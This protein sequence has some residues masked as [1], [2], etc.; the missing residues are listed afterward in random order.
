MDSERILKQ[1]YDK[2]N[3]EKGYPSRDSPFLCLVEPAG[4]EPAS[5]SNPLADLHA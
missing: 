3:K 4:I 2:I 1:I 5:V